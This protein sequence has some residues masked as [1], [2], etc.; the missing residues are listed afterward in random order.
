MATQD[1]ML[2]SIFLCTVC[3]VQPRRK[4]GAIHCG[5]RLLYLLYYRW[6]GGLKSFLEVHQSFQF[7]YSS[8]SKFTHTYT[9]IV[10]LV[11]T[12]LN[13]LSHNKNSTNCLQPTAK[14]LR[15]PNILDSIS[16]LPF[17]SE[18]VTSILVWFST[19]F[20]YDG[21]IMFS[22]DSDLFNKPML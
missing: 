9:Y 3:F 2:S 19:L 4:V 17:M 14:V 6:Q 13:S 16:C 20:L 15:R 10:G 8:Q 22:N 7:N 21:F 12:A 1:L 5:N 18:R 11:T